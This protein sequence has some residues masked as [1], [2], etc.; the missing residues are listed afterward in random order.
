MLP[1]PRA[2]PVAV[3]GAGVS[4]LSCAAALSEA[5][6]EHKVEVYEAD[7]S[8]VGGRLRQTQTR[9]WPVELGAQFVHGTD[10]E[11]SK[12]L[13]QALEKAGQ[14]QVRSIP[15]PDA[16]WSAEGGW[17]RA[18]ADAALKGAESAMENLD[19]AL[20][21]ASVA[22]ALAAQSQATLAMASAVYANDYGTDLSRLG[23]AAVASELAA[24]ES[25]EDY[26]VLTGE[27]ARKT[28]ANWSALVKSLS[29]SLTIKRG[30]RLVRVSHWQEGDSQ[31]LMLHFEDGQTVK[32]EVAVIAL[33]LTVLREGDVV[34]DP[35]LPAWKTR[36][37]CVMQMDN[38]LKVR[39]Q[40]ANKANQLH[41]DEDTLQT[42]LVRTIR[43]CLSRWLWR[44]VFQ[45]KESR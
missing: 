38:C 28:N 23:A 11:A 9:A 8:H 14:K 21:S 15:W 32:A 39:F 2:M 37:W 42:I 4:G 24:W 31:P 34:F 44:Q 29:D 1:P 30:A 36:A 10:G 20:S 6:L 19:G 5:P 27:D 17:R 35:P 13:L 25:G 40:V 7:E 26:G 18:E 16:C 33:P 12:G 43:R 3:V 45:F 22:H 41:P